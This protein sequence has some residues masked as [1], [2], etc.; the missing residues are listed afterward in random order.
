MSA[1]TA[2]SMVGS[3]CG[4]VVLSG[5]EECEVELRRMW[6]KKVD[7]NCGD[8]GRRMWD[9]HRQWVCTAS[10]SCSILQEFDS[11]KSQRKCR[12]CIGSFD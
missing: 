1:E 3:A 2:E 7:C 11:F 4:G 8:C 10:S 6:A 9:R 12:F 5:V